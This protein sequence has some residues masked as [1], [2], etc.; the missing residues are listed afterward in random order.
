MK[1]LV[2]A[3]G[4]LLLASASAQENVTMDVKCI[5]EAL[6]VCSD[7][8]PLESQNASRRLQETTVGMFEEFHATFKRSDFQCLHTCVQGSDDVISDACRKELAINMPKMGTCFQVAREKCPHDC[9]DGESEEA[10]SA[11]V[12]ACRDEEDEVQEACVILEEIET[13]V[14]E[15]EACK[16]VVAEQCPGECQEG[17]DMSVCHPPFKACLIAN[18]TVQEACAGISLQRHYSRKHSNPAT[19][20]APSASPEEQAL[21]DVKCIEEALVVCSDICPIEGQTSR[22][23]LQDTSMG[24]FEE[25]HAAFKRSDIECLRTCI[26]DASDDVLS[27]T[28]RNDLATIMPNVH[29]CFQ[30]ANEK[31]PHDCEAGES[32]EAC[33]A[34]VDACRDAEDE[35]QEACVILEEIETAASAVESCKEVVAEQCP[36]QCKE[37]EDR[38]VCHGPFKTCLMTNTPVQEACEGISLKRH[39]SGKYS[40]PGSTAAPSP[41]AMM[42]I[43]C[44]EEALVECSDMCRT[45]PYDGDKAT[46]FVDFHRTFK[47]SDMDC[48]HTCIQASTDVLSEECLEDLE[49]T[50]PKVDNCYKTA[51][52]ECPTVCGE[53]ESSQECTA[54]ILSCREY[55]VPMQEAC[56][57]LDVIEAASYAVES[58][59]AVV[60][61]ECPNQCKPGEDLS[62]CHGPFKKC[63]LGS[64]VVE[65]ACEGISLQRHYSGRKGNT[66]PP[67]PLDVKCVEEALFECSEKCVAQPRRLR[68]RKLDGSSMY[69]EFHNTFKTSDMDCLQQCTRQSDILSEA[70]ISELGEVL[71]DVASC[72][73][74]AEKQCPSTCQAGES[75]SEC[76][77][78][79]ESCRENDTEMQSACFVLGTLE[80][81]VVDLEE[82]K[83]VVAAECPMECQPGEDVSKCHP[84]F[85]ACIL[86]ND[87]VSKACEG[88]SLQRHYSQG[89]GSNQQTTDESDDESAEH[90]K[91]NVS[92]EGAIVITLI[93]LLL[94]MALFGVVARK[95]LLKTALSTNEEKVSPEG[96]GEQNA[97]GPEVDA[98]SVEIGERQ[99]NSGNEAV[100]AT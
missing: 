62:V 29:S 79:I 39:F 9:E 17:D 46:T 67:D 18:A 66:A 12:D 21:M 100:V 60:A 25:F 3:A 83:A 78:R 77:S 14:K 85:K 57:I 69:E 50:I 43:K 41:K 45:Q 90:E 64:P 58:C 47:T 92:R 23:R 1:L 15:V 20:V 35:V 61:V 81:A 38:S 6:V 48:L 33:A 99:G 11:R 98:S 42:D 55:S 53:E 87:K 75:D 10:C 5:E 97:N 13:A 80:A 96:E 73:D 44:I 19:T 74:V 70:C 91:R 22:R 7:I 84:E 31:C 65:K 28:C 82:C 86:G 54:R 51:E 76:S 59:K 2:V 52:K 94:C 72:Y 26:Q 63:I 16:A 27:A 68:S 36:G 95:V 8:C 37:G 89:G 30:V 34:R 40:A 32:E 56:A 93:V 49:E 71:A 88:I 24:M 4:A